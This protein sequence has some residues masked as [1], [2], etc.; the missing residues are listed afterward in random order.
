LGSRTGDRRAG[1]SKTG[2]L[3]ALASSCCLRLECAA[4]PAAL[5]PAAVEDGEYALA[6]DVNVLYAGI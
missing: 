6:V 1:R 3:A 5:R 2:V 4:L